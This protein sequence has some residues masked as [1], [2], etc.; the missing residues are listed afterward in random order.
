MSHVSSVMVGLLA[1]VTFITISLNNVSPSTAFK[2][3]FELAN[4]NRYNV[5]LMHDNSSLYN[6]SD[7]SIKWSVEPTAYFYKFTYADDL[8]FILN[9][10]YDTNST[11]NVT[12]CSYFVTLDDRYS[13]H[14][15]LF[16]ES[17][18]YCTPTGYWD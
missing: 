5:S 12:A 14:V 4:Y 13:V 11:S 6:S 15:T 17:L 2:D 16:N 7:P 8:Q 18:S 1:I 9:S 10:S 3:T